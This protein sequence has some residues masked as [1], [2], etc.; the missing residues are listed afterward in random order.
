[1]SRRRHD[2]PAEDSW[3]MVDG[4]NDSFDTSLLPSFSDGGYANDPNNSNGPHAVLRPLSSGF[5]SQ[6]TSSSQGTNPSQPRPSQPDSLNSNSQDSIR[7]FAAYGEDDQVILREPFRPSLSSRAG[8]ASSRVLLAGNHG[9]RSPEP[10]FRMPMVDID[11]Y[12][13]RSSGN[14]SRTVRQLDYG[15]GDTD[16][17]GMRRR[18]K[19]K[20]GTTR[21]QPYGHDHDQ[22][23]TYPARSIKDH[24]GQSLPAALYGIFL[25]ALDVIGLSFRYARRPI[26]FLLAIYLLFGGIILVGNSFTSSVLVALSPLCRLPGASLLGLPFCS[27]PLPGGNAS[28]GAASLDFDDLMHVQLKFEDLLERNSEAVSLPD[29]LSRSSIAVRDLRILVRTSE[30]DGREELMPHLDGYI[31]SAN[32]IVH[33]LIRFNT[34]LGGTVDRILI[35]NR[36]TSRYIDSLADDGLSSSS[37]LSL[38]GWAAWVFAPFQP[39]SQVFTEQGLREQYIKHTSLVS[40]RIDSLVTEA[41]TVRHLLDRADDHLSS[42]YEITTRS[43]DALASSRPLI[44]HYLGTVLH[45]LALH[46]DRFGRQLALLG[47]VEA[48]RAT[49]AAQLADLVVQ[50]KTIRASLLELHDRVEDPGPL[51]LGPGGMPLSVHIDTINSGVERLAAT[52]RR[53]QAEEDDARRARVPDDQPL[54]EA[55]KHRA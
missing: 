39:S 40:E 6:P 28:T 44:L 3:R 54:I 17:D 35:I 43:S 36:W 4:E 48:Q 14:S 33:D 51:A 26:A 13:R 29:E 1:M 7:D 55:D 23:G 5:P 50:L 32:E 9:M 37:S 18:G 46:P 10:E 24:V 31:D 49:A 16:G 15:F 2:I 38:A 25:W 53:I 20:R 27:L 45:Q 21:R 42:I 11:R 52:R 12:D 34:R 19:G 8:S 30:L 41:E 22:R 47:R